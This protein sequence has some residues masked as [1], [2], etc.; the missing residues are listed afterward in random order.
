MATAPPHVPVLRDRV[1]ALFADL[2]EGPIVDATLGAG[3][4]AFAIAKAQQQAHPGRFPWIIG[5]DRDPAARELAQSRFAALPDVRI[6]IVAARFD[7]LPEILETHGVQHI[8]GAL[9]D[10]GLSSMQIDTPTR[11]FAYRMDGPLDMRMDPTLAVSAADLVNDSAP[12]EL[13]RILQLFGEERFAHRIVQAIVDARP[14]T[15]TVQLADIVK[16]AIPAA[17]RR[18]GGHPAT[19]TFQALRIAVNGEIE[20][21]ERALPAALEHLAV[22]GVCAVVSYHSLEDRIVKS[23]FADAT[24][25]CI[26]PPRL[27]VCACGRTPIFDDVIR[28]P[29]RP[30]ESE[31]AANPRAR[32][33]RLRAVRRIK[34]GSP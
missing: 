33:A 16:H 3:G 26:C 34:P 10:L 4:H 20:A 1:V 13:V 9:F 7:A 19:R 2:V 28:R 25:G 17:A 11:G 15:T 24:R 23:A 21:L 18:S 31:I 6:D 22:G 27:P 5:I 12:A 30:S 32:S 14:V 8:S 29:E